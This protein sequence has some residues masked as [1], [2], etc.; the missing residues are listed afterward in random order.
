M[1]ISTQCYRDF[2][3]R[4]A[5]MISSYLPQGKS[6]RKVNASQLGSVVKETGI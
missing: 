2:S 1:D 6:F 3:G 4:I 5:K